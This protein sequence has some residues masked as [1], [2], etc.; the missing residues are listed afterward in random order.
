[1]AR[2]YITI[3]SGFKLHVKMWGPEAGHPVIALHGWMDNAAT[4]D[5]LAP[6]LSSC[7]IAAIDLPG[8][9]FSDHLPEGAH[10]AVYDAIPYV[11]AVADQLDWSHFSIIGHSMGGGI[12]QV[13]AA[14]YPERVRALVS[15]DMLGLF[16][17]EPDTIVDQLAAYFQE[18][19]R[20]HKP[21]RVY[22]SLEEA[23]T[24]RQLNSDMRFESAKTLVAGGMSAVDG[25]YI[26]AFDPNIRK[27]NML[28]LTPNQLAVILTAIRAPFHVLVA[29]EGILAAQSDLVERA[30]QLASP[31]M[32]TVP[33]GHH[34][35]LDDAQAVAEILATVFAA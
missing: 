3:A 7:R 33:G 18:Y 29:Q 16:T 14:V 13:M 1:M 2:S 27:R 34:V 15:L 31:V 4:F 9:G 19:F 17:G 6:L 12:G 26:W 11:L 8:H 28:R 20:E 22:S 23:A 10:H 30:V 5:H 25:G 32:H 24:V 35:H 21:N